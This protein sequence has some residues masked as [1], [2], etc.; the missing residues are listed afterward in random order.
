M[1]DNADSGLFPD[2][3]GAAAWVGWQCRQGDR[4]RTVAEGSTEREAWDRL[5]AQMATVTCGAFDNAI[6]PCGQGA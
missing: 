2:Q 6:L 4:W 1:P 5:Y 3:P